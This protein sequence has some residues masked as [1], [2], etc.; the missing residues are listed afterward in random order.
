[1][2]WSTFYSRPVQT[3][4]LFAFLESA[5]VVA[6]GSNW[7][8]WWEWELDCNPHLAK[9]MIDRSFSEI[10]LREMLERAT[11]FR[12]DVT[13][14]RWVV[15]TTHNRRAWEVIVE[16][17]DAAKRLIVVTAYPLD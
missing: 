16:P 3:G 17:D 4:R 12:P 13:H 8:E 10:D 14:G 15:E 9:R 2:I 5:I 1:M 7:P 6:A 11:G